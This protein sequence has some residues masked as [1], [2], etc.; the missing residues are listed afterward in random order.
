MKKAKTIMIIYALIA[1]LFIT[2]SYS[3]LNNNLYISG[4]V[5]R[6]NVDVRVTNI[7]KV[8]FL[9]NNNTAYWDGCEFSFDSS[10][11]TGTAGLKSEYTKGNGSMTNPYVV[12]EN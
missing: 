7:V 5:L 12:K 9:D 8:N 1:S 2:Y 4:G 10:T 3:A 11:C 6:A